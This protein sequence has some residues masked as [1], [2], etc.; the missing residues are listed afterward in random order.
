MAH[1]IEAA[2]PSRAWLD[3]I[4]WLAQEP[5]GKAVNLNV[6]F[7]CTDEEEPIRAEIDALLAGLDSTLSKD[8]WPV[9]TVANTIFPEALY[10]PHLGTSAASLLYENYAL[11]MRLQRHAENPYDRETYFNRLVSYPVADGSFNQLKWIV[12]RL[13]EVRGRRSQPSSDYELGISHPFDAELRVQAPGRDKRFLWFPC[14]SH[15]SLTL[16]GGTI[17]MTAV[18]RNQ[19]F[20]TRAY[21]NYLGLSRLLR[22]ITTETG[23]APG[24]I[25]VVATH[26]D[27]NFNLGKGRVQHLIE[28]CHALDHAGEVTVGA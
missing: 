21:G 4:T 18:Y 8:I 26:A 15:I 23:T 10:H 25:E 19:T 9:Q 20:V 11:S 3:A 1:L 12:E 2:N 27:A 5:E 16:T 7:L 14:L 22:F 13:N 6:A 28:R 17:S 24:E